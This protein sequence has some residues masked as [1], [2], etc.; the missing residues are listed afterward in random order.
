MAT[1]KLDEAAI[2]DIARQIEAPE[3]RLLFIQMACGEDR[4]LQ[5]RVEALLRVNDEQGNFPRVAGGKPS[6]GHQCHVQ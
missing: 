3:A 2:F 5:A 4:D 6:R 1:L